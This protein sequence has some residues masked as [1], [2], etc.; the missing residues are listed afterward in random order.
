M[1]T[2]MY[3]DKWEI[4]DLEVDAKIV[5]TYLQRTPATVAVFLRMRN[6]HDMVT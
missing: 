6:A 4:K 1:E 2:A 3:L 5:F